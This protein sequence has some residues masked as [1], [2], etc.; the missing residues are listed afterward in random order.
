[1]PRGSAPFL[2]VAGDQRC[3][4]QLF[5]GTS[6]PALMALSSPQAHPSTPRPSQQGIFVLQT[7]CVILGCAFATR[8]VLKE[9]VSLK[10]S[11]KLLKKQRGSL[12]WDTA[13]SQRQQEQQR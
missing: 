12:A 1:M 5:G 9:A 10:S 13:E 6:I 8:T 11:R 3:W 2:A 4:L 7:N